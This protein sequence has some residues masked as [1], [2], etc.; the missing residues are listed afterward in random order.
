[1]GVSTSVF[2]RACPLP[3]RYC[4]TDSVVRRI[5]EV[6]SWTGGCRWLPKLKIALYT[7]VCIF[8]V[9]SLNSWFVL[10]MASHYRRG[11]TVTD[12]LQLTTFPILATESSKT[13]LINNKNIQCDARMSQGGMRVYHILIELLLYIS[14]TSPW[15]FCR[16]RYL[17]DVRCCVPVFSLM[18][19]ASPVNK[20]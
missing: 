14:G 11:Y 3:R 16:C 4:K 7:D 9:I 18:I 15:I 20:V 2:C 8:H 13:P 10:Y 19:S 5:F 12:H 6:L 1:M 17:A